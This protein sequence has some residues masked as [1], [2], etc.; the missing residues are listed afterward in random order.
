MIQVLVS[1]VI[2]GSN[3]QAETDQRLDVLESIGVVSSKEKALLMLSD[4]VTV[5]EVARRV[6]KNR[7]TIT[8]WRDEL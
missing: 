1:A 6:G 2:E 5:A 7:K 8:R 3:K 4:G